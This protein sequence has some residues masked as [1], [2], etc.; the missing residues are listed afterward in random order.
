[1]HQ[2]FAMT[3]DV[4]HKANDIPTIVACG[5]LAAT[6]AA[7]CH[8]TIGHGTSC[9]V[10]GGQLVLLTSIWFRCQGATSITYVAG[11]IASLACGL[12]GLIFLRRARKNITRLVLSL[13]SAFSLFW[14]AGQLISQPITNKDVWSIIADRLQWPPFWRPIAIILGISSY[15]LTLQMLRR[16]LHSGAPVRGQAILI[17]YLAGVAS[18]AIAGLMWAAMP[19]RSAVEAI[20]TL[21]VNS[22]G[23]ILIALS[24]EEHR[25]LS[26]VRILRSIPL[27]AVSAA[28][29]LIFVLVQ[30]RGLGSLAATALAL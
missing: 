28:A 8:E 17:G 18:A 4:E 9:R 21:G 13:F 1:M 29:F 27:I 5:V 3:Q 15:V 12:T 11:P 20:L 30:G 19:M 14:F 23:L 7:V 6:L 2:V 25:N 16:T 24:A 22:I 26:H 10:E